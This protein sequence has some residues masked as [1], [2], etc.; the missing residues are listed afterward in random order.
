[1]IV[2]GSRLRRFTPPLV[3]DLVDRWNPRAIRLDDTVKTWAEA[4]A[5]SD[6]YASQV[7]AERVAVATREVVGGR[8]AFERDGVAF[9]AAEFNWPVITHLLWVAAEK[10]RLRVIDFGGSL[11]SIFWQHRSF[12]RNVSEV[13]WTVVEQPHF[14][15]KGRAEFETPQLHFATFD[16]LLSRPVEA[17][18]VLLSSVLQYLPEPIMVTELLTASGAEY[19]LIDKTPVI[20]RA[21]SVVA[22]QKVPK[23]I[24]PVSYPLW[25][26]SSS[27]LDR[28]T[29]KPWKARAMWDCPGPHRTKNGIGVTWKGRFLTRFGG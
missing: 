1:M 9:A 18:I 12:F 5:A 15:A 26:F 4:L 25:L 23:S 11:G 10:G 22:V 3:I 7:V 17:D 20:E 24:Y 28:I 2:A 8:A 14:V 19:V 13:S 16:E 6:G 21:D 29:P 27:D